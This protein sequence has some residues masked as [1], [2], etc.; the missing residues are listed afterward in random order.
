[1]EVR[2][3]ACGHSEEGEAVEVP[4]AGALPHLIYALVAVWI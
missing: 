4:A 1:M 3:E 2:M